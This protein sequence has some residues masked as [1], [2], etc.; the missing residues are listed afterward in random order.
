MMVTM[1]TT[2]N[3][4]WWL[5]SFELMSTQF[6]WLRWI[7]PINNRPIFFLVTSCNKR[8]KMSQY[9]YCSY[10]LVICRSV[11]CFFISWIIM[12]GKFQLWTSGYNSWIMM[13]ERHEFRSAESWSGSLE[14]HVREWAHN[15]IYSGSR[16]FINSIRTYITYHHRP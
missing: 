13:S 15:F 9:Y 2:F 5:P 3:A 4:H 16:L 1:M 12:F 7:L 8:L 14:L 10:T 6:L 11:E